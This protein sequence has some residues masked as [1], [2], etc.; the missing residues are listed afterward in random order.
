[1]K[2]DNANLIA[3]CESDLAIQRELVEMLDAVGLRVANIDRIRAVDKA[4]DGQRWVSARVEVVMRPVT[5]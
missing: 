5:T 1:M 2:R 3:R 4:R